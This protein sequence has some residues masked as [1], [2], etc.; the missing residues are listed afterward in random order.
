M[1]LDLLARRAARL[2]PSLPAAHFP[3]ELAAGVI[4]FDSGFAHPPLMPDLGECAIAAAGRYRGQS[5]QYSGRAGLLDLRESI[6]A[7]MRADG[8]PADPRDIMLVNGAKHGIELACR[9]L[10]DEGDCIAVTAPTYFTA[11]PIFR[12]FGV[13]FLEVT[14]D[15][16]G[17]RVDE[18]AEAIEQRRADGRALPKFVYDMPDFHNPTGITMS[19]AR[20]RALL[21]L[22]QR[23]GMLVLEDSPYRSVRFEGEP[24]PTLRSLDGGERVIHIGTFSKL[25]AP[26]LR[27]GWVHARKD[28]LARMMQLK[29][30]GGSSAFMHR[31]VAE[32]CRSPAYTEHAAKVRNVYAAHRD[33]MLAALARELPDVKWTRPEGGYYVW[34]T[35]P[36]GVDGGEL[37][38]NAARHGVNIIPAQKFHAGERPYP[39]NCVRLTY[40]F[41]TLEQIDEGVGRLA[42]VMR[43]MG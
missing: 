10:L 38:T 4:S 43:S 36:P 6:A 34:L 28:L 2:S 8:A 33:R 20:R 27:V 11:I 22:A 15:A 12:S 3:S 14:Q 23:Y 7:Q 35:L 30:D 9:L 39:R 13:Q 18:L 42:R 25:I 31:L 41:P 32:F 26:G 24:V 5:L 1:S 16:E 19:L 17:L 21:E 40:S 37:A 29:S